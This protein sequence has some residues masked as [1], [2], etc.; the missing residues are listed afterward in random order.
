LGD[1]A[2]LL[3]KKGDKSYTLA[4]FSAIGVPIH[5]INIFCLKISLLMRVPLLFHI[6]FRMNR[7][8]FFVLF[9]KHSNDPDP[10]DNI[11]PTKTDTYNLKKFVPRQ[12][13]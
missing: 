11:Y 4:E 13:I 6:Y 9:G 7:V 1:K 12:K 2:S 3:Q 8:Q 5:E 10:T